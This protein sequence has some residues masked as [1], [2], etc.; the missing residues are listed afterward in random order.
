MITASPEDIM[1]IETLEGYQFAGSALAFKPI[2]PL[3]SDILKALDAKME[4]NTPSKT[5][6]TKDKLKGILASRYNGELKLLNLSNLA[7]DAGLK[8][9]GVFD[10]TTTTSKIFPALMAICDGLF[11]SRKAKLDAVL[12][13]T[14]ADNGLTTISDVF[15][16]GSTFP[17]LK[18]LDLSRNNLADLRSIDGWKHKF[19]SLEN[20]MLIGNPIEQQ[21]TTLKDELLKRYPK[22]QILNNVQLRTAEDIAAARAA[23]KARPLAIP[24]QDP[25]FRDVAQVGE[26]FIRQFLPLYDS[27][28]TQLASIYYD[29]ESV[30]SISI[31]MVAPHEKQPGSGAIPQWHPYTPHSRNLVK[32][33]HLPSRMGR[34]KRGLQQIQELW[35]SLPATR[36]PDLQT[37]SEK[38]I[39]ECNSIPG[40]SDPSG[41]NPGGVDG[42]MLTIHG[43]FEEPPPTPSNS[44]DRAMRSFSRTFILGPG[45][46][47]NNPIRVVSDMMVLRA[48]SPVARPVPMSAQPQIQTPLPTIP[49]E[50]LQQQMMATPVQIT[51]QQRQEAMAIE[52]VRKSGMTLE[53]SVLCLTETGWNFD[54]AFAAFT[55]NKVGLIL[56]NYE[57]L[58]TSILIQQ[59]DKLPAEA[60]MA[61]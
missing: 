32:I 22:L 5:E 30:A 54:Q 14:L 52:L 9:M 48:W 61:R 34:Q 53:Y 18:N 41:V 46:P 44:T 50:P 58:Y 3:A 13:V 6:E 60:W 36:H 47:G 16:L 39:I 49:L 59:Q 10:G 2:G 31:N 4:T 43:E 57:L 38:Y 29:A 24:I 21:L 26:N 51:D 40:L 1:T 42:L 27:N 19:R 33:T 17:D 45:A 25:S 11:E 15:A 12:S 8:E 55:A 20:L 7:N 56:S 35:A 28:R 37:S 23:M